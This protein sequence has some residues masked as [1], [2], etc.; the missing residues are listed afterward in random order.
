MMRRFLW[1]VPA[2]ALASAV[3]A[4]RAATLHVAPDGSDAWS[5]RLARPS[6]ANAKTVFYV[7]NLSLTNDS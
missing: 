7:D 2:V 3:A 6:N 4:G 1:I 5:G